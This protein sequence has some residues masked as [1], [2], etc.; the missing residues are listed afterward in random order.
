MRT[1]VVELLKR[2]LAKQETKDA[3]VQVLSRAMEDDLGKHHRAIA[4]RNS[5]G[6]GTLAAP[7]CVC[8]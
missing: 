6:L 3:L 1:Q 5:S 7:P 4:C 8:P 2:V